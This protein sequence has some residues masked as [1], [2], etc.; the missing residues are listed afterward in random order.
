MVSTARNGEIELRFVGE[1]DETVTV[2]I[3]DE[4]AELLE[5]VS[6]PL[7]LSSLIRFL[8]LFP[9]LLL[10]LC[11]IVVAMLMNLPRNRRDFVEIGGV[12]RLKMMCAVW[13][14]R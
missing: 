13:L 4:M 10:L 5:R 3:L 6:D 12:E 14:R 2:S 1:E 8:L 9:F 7:L 11:R